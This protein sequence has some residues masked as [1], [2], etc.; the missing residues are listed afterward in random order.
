MSKTVPFQTIRYSI[1]TQF[2][3]KYTVYLSKTFLFK[4]IQFIQTVLIQTIQFSISVQLILFNTKIGPYQVLP[5]WT[6]EQWHFPKLQHH[7][8]LIIRLL[9]VL[10]R[11]LIGGILPLF[12]GAVGEF[13]SPSKT[14]VEEMIL[15][16]DLNNSWFGKYYQR[17]NRFGLWRN[18]EITT[19]FV[20]TSSVVVWTANRLIL[21]GEKHTRNYS[22]HLREK[23]TNS[24]TYTFSS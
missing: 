1:S 23:N 21:K 20:A 8:N 17:R 2:K 13:Y 22:C 7:W 18:V 11:T 15:K 16:F 3:C 19:E 14:S 5:E 4:A 9:S 10:S 6:W 12:R 24:Q